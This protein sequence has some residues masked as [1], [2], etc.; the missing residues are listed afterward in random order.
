M[1]SMRAH[2]GL[3]ISALTAGDKSDGSGCSWVIGS[4]EIWPAQSKGQ[5]RR[6]PSFRIN[7]PR[8]S[9]GLSEKGT[10]L[11]C[12]LRLQKEINPSAVQLSVSPTAWWRL[13]GQGLPGVGTESC[14]TPAWS[15]DSVLSVILRP[16]LPVLRSSTR[17]VADELTLL[18]L[19]MEAET[20]NKTP[21][22]HTCT[23]THT[24][25]HTHQTSQN[26]CRCHHSL[27]YQQ[28]SRNTND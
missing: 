4:A 2:K 18:L 7:H 15:G 20:P 25:A 26:L 3:R 10:R 11:L 22:T 14:L 5:P 19:N 13:K 1:K 9:T 28:S 12:S 16:T 23:D 27:C 24:C 17:S 8:E 6:P 21:Y